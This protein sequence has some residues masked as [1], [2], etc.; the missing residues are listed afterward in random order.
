MDHAPPAAEPA[1]FRAFPGLTN[2]VPWMAL[3][4]FP[5]RVE[6]VDGLAPPSVELWVKRDDQSGAIYGGT[7]ALLDRL[8]A[9]GA[10]VVELGD[11]VRCD[12]FVERVGLEGVTPLRVLD[13]VGPHS[14]LPAVDGDGAFGL[15]A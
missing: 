5:T 15:S 10:T 11:E 7:K 2:K 9:V 8:H 14:G 3:G 13:A 4:R 6:R 12:Q 1:L